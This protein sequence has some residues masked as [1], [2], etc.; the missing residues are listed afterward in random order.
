MINNAI[1]STSKISKVFPGTLALNEVDFE[2]NE[3]EVHAIIGENGAGKST[4]IK[5]LCG[6]YTEYSGILYLDGKQ[7][8]FDNPRESSDAGIRAIYQEFENLPK[9]SV[10]ENIYMGRLPKNKHIPGFVDWSSLIQNTDELLKD[11]GID[12]EPQAKLSSLSVAQQQLVEIAKAISIKLKILIMDEP[13]SFLAT[14]EVEQLFRII[15]TLKKEQN[16]SVIYISHRLNEVVDIADRITVLRDGQNVGTLIKKDFKEDRLIKMMI[17]HGLSEQ[18]EMSIAKKEIILEARN[19]NIYK[20]LYDFNMKLY[21]GEILGIAGLIG[22]GKDEFIKCL[23]GLWPRQSGEIFLYGGKFDVK[24]PYDLIGKDVVYLPE[25]RKTQALF[26]ELSL[27]ENLSPIWLYKIFNKYILS[28]GREYSVTQEYM[29]K[30]SIKAVNTEQEVINLSGGNQQ[31]V[32]FARLLSIRPRVLLL[33]DPTRGIDVGSK[34]E[35]Y[36]I[37]TKLAEQGSSILILSSEVQEICSLSHR[38]IV[39]S[40]GRTVGEFEGE[41]IDVETVLSYAMLS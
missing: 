28:K 2:L 36:R 30:L 37:I 24:E 7:I 9:L 14:H 15:Y 31:K 5:I 32:I 35:I 18:K 25:E 16:V 26:L 20:R 10:A 3:G 11:L 33:H 38:I 22:S 6:I 34:E 19:I 12:L 39:L 13:T 4:F 23:F 8:T 17:G 29:N 27:R 1:L 41:S 40:K 21:E